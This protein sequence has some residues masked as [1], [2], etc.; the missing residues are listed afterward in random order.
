[1]F[2]QGLAVITRDPQA[3]PLARTVRADGTLQPAQI[4]TRGANRVVLESGERRAASCS[5]TPPIPAGR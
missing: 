4:L 1:M 2:R 3:L 5:P